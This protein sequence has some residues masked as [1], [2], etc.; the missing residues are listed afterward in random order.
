[1]TDTFPLV[2]PALPMAD[3]LH[4]YGLRL[5]DDRALT[6]QRA[7][8]VSDGLRRGPPVRVDPQAER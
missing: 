2:V 8:P 5:S 6:E 4:E 1:M 7:G 3:V